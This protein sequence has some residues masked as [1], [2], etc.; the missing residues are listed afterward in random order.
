MHNSASGNLIQKRLLCGS[1]TDLA[2]SIC[3][4]RCPG[5]PSLG[6]KEGNAVSTASDLPSLCLAHSYAGAGYSQSAL[7]PMIS[8][9][10]QSAH[11]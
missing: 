8:G 6:A 9:P 7:Q 10:T 11:A 5:V 3:P 1:S 4:A 2:S